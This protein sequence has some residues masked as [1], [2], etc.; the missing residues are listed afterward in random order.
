MRR[1]VFSF[2][3]FRYTQ[4]QPNRLASTASASP[5]ITPKHTMAIPTIN[6][7]TCTTGFT[8]LNNLDHSFRCAIIGPYRPKSVLSAI[9]NVQGDCYAYFESSKTSEHC[10]TQSHAARETWHT[11][12]TA[13]TMDGE[14]LDLLGVESSTS[15]CSTSISPYRRHDRAQGLRKTDCEP[16]F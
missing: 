1:S 6:K 4:T 5:R 10:A 11:A 3:Q 13:A 15:W 2:I 9:W 12:S 16:R 7:A 14:A 8:A